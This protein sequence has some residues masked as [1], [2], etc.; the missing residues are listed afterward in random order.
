M[1]PTRLPI[2][3]SSGGAPGGALVVTNVRLAGPSR[4]EADWTAS[5][6]LPTNLPPGLY[7]PTISAGFQGIPLTA[8][9]RDVLPSVES[10]PRM[11]PALPPIRVGAAGKQR[12]YW[13]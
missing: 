5:F 1:T 11:G 8:R 3:E 4:L 2:E 6:L 9:H 10:G 13:V 7:R 12:L